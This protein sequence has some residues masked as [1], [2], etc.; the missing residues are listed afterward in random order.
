LLDAYR[1]EYRESVALALEARAQYRA[2][3][4]FLLVP[5]ELRL[6]DWL[7]SW[8]LR[9]GTARLDE[10]IELRVRHL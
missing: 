5:G 7:P 9:V 6:P 10:L 8:V 3:W 1:D 4:N 2:R